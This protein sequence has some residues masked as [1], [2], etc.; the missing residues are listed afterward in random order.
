MEVTGNSIVSE[1]ISTKVP[2]SLGINLHKHPDSQLLSKSVGQTHKHINTAPNILSNKIL[3]NAMV[4]K[5]ILILKRINCSFNHIS[6]RATRFSLFDF[7]TFSKTRSSL[8]QR[9][10]IVTLYHKS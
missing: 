3:R 9:L 6:L 8:R 1:K 7:Y 10:T 2:F 4:N 5:F